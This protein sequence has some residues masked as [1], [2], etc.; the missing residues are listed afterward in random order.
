MCA[1][2]STILRAVVVDFFFNCWYLDILL[3]NLIR[4]VPRFVHYRAQGHKSV[5]P[6]WFEYC[7]IYEKFVACRV[8]TFVRVTDTFWSG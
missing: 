3:D 7:F 6:D 4:H 1:E 5:S 8:L 2:A